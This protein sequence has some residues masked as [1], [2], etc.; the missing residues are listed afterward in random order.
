MNKKFLLVKYFKTD[1]IGYHIIVN[2]LLIILTSILIYNKHQVSK[3]LYLCSVSGLSTAVVCS[4]MYII[5]KIIS[6]I[7]KDKLKMH[8]VYVFAVI[9]DLIITSKYG[10]IAL[11]IY[12]W[13][14][15]IWACFSTVKVIEIVGISMFLI[16]VI[17]FYIDIRWDLENKKRF[18]Y[19]N[20]F[21]AIPNLH[22]LDKIVSK[23][24]A[25]L[26]ESLN[27]SPS[28]LVHAYYTLNGV[29]NELNN[30]I[31][32]PQKG[33]VAKTDLLNVYRLIREIYLIE[34]LGKD[35]VENIKVLGNLKLHKRKD[36]NYKNLS[37]EY[38]LEWRM[39]ETAPSIDV[40]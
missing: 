9:N 6:K 26:K 19:E 39:N 30:S 17:C 2:V 31:A 36:N 27:I 14:L 35:V 7:F 34:Q 1:F 33:K 16:S 25:D 5:D 13:G 4:T 40:V 32:L 28:Y 10:K 20:L 23:E 24:V 15:S 38:N 21:M 11:Y 8:P 29:I 18:S 22:H 12:L 3:Y 37:D